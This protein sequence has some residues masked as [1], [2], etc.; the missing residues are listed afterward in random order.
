MHVMV[1]LETMSTRAD[2]AIVAIGAVMFTEETIKDKFY[3]VVD[4]NDNILRGRHVEG[5]TVLWWLKQSNEA[6]KELYMANQ[7]LKLRDALDAFSNWYEVASIQSPYQIAP[8][9]GNGADF[10]NAILQHAYKTAFDEPRGTPWPYHA[11][12]CYRTVKRMFP[13][14]VAKDLAGSV[15]HRADHDAEY[16]AQHLQEIARETGISLR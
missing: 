12:R 11:N 16:Q 7:P 5:G 14:V 8:I 1:D 6:R 2:A 15:A 13:H 10:D 4:L 9:W 3:A